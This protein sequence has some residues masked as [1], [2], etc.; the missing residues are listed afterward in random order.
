[1]SRSF[2]PRLRKSAAGRLEHCAVSTVKDGR[3]DERNLASTVLRL[4]GRS[5]PVQ[6]LPDAADGHGL[7]LGREVRGTEPRR[8]H[9]STSRSSPIISPTTRSRSASISSNGLGGTYSSKC[10]VKGISYRVLV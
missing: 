9:P 5:S 1:N 3:R 10:R 8:R 4:R 2:H 7:P 6:H